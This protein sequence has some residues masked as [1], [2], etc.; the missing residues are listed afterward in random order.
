MRVRESSFRG[1]SVRSVCAAA[2]AV[3]ICALGRHVGPWIGAWQ[4][5]HKQRRPASQSRLKA[6]RIPSVLRSH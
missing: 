2:A 5:P 3:G 6:G 1:I 4:E